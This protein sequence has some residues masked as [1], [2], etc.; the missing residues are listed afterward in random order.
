[1]KK[2]RIKRVL[3][4]TVV[5][6]MSMVILLTLFGITA[7]AALLEPSIAGGEA[8]PSPGSYFKNLYE[9]G[10]GLAGVLAVLFIVIGG[11]EY[12]ASAANPSAKESAKKRIWAAI[13]GLLL[14]LASYLILQTINPALVGI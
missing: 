8:N 1:M 3:R 12:I 2:Q 5:G 4:N 14:A 13:G 10:V 7:Y 6:G 9:I 11:L